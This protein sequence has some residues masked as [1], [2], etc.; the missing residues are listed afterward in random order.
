MPIDTSELKQRIPG[1]GADLDR[2]KRPGIPREKNQESVASGQAPKPERQVSH[3]R[4]LKSTEHKELT[5][6][7]GTSC[8]LKG[9]SGMIREYAYTWSEGRK[10]HWLLLLLADRVDVIESGLGSVLRGTAHNPF[11]EAGFATEIRNGGFKTRFGQNRSD[12]NRFAKE[13]AL[14]LGVGAVVFMSLR[15]RSRRDDQKV[16]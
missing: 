4:I 11:K 6:V 7:F 12:L 3:L 8:P 1:W 13:A 2:S 5:P 10:R 15:K 14:L 16:A 9:L